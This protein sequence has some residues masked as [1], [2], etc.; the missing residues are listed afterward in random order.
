MDESERI[1]EKKLY[2]ETNFF[3]THLSFLKIFSIIGLIKT[4]KLTKIIDNENVKLKKK[5][6]MFFFAWI[7]V[8]ISSI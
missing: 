4:E 3:K 5:R 7:A 6:L 1:D 8:F 2:L